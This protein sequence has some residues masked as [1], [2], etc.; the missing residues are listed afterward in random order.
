MKRVVFIAATQSGTTETGVRFKKRSPLSRGIQILAMASALLVM[1][2]ISAC[3]SGNANSSSVVAPDNRLVGVW[4]RDEYGGR[5]YVFFADGTYSSGGKS[6][7]S[8]SGIF[9]GRYSIYDNVLIL[10]RNAGNSGDIVDQLYTFNITGGNLELTPYG[11]DST[12]TFK[13]VK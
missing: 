10:I 11:S 7:S 6:D 2:P 4:E 9:V 3:S 1:F 13:K 12:I 8:G 5:R